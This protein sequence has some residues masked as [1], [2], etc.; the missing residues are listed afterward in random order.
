[1]RFCSIAERSG[2][3]TARPP[4]AS[5]SWKISSIG[6]PFASALL[7]PVIA[8]AIGL[9]E[10]T[11]TWGSVVITASPIERRVTSASSRS[12]CSASS[13]ALRWLM[14]CTWETK[15]SGA[16]AASR[17]SD[18]LSRMCTT[19]PSLWKLRFSSW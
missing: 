14:F 9:S 6:R 12:R 17:T 4:W 8:S 5:N 7:Q 13:K 19:W 11:R 1:M 15:Y 18:T 3:A 2:L 10:V 16:P